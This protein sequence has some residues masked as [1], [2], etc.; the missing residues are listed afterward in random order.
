MSHA[1]SNRNNS[2]KKNKN[3]KKKNKN[4]KKKGSGGDRHHHVIITIALVKQPTI[5]TK[6]SSSSISVLSSACSITQQMQDQLQ[7]QPQMA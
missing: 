2:S 1:T 7:S 5:I 4:K 3:K 6:L